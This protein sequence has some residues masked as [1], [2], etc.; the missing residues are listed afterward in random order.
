[1]SFTPIYLS[2]R[3]FTPTGG[4]MCPSTGATMKRISQLTTYARPMLLALHPLYAP[5][6]LA[7]EMEKLL[8]TRAL[9]EQND[10]GQPYDKQ[11]FEGE[12]SDM[13]A[14]IDTHSQ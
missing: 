2:L 3:H 11:M 13:P 7:S 10:V 6:A 14:S 12:I 8:D 1:M 4:R 9:V 5:V